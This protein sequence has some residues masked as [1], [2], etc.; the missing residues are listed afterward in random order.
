ME[1][2]TA[3]QKILYDQSAE[4]LMA[5]TNLTWHNDKLYAVFHYDTDTNILLMMAEVDL[6]N[7]QEIQFHPIT[8]YE[9]DV[10]PM[11]FF[12]N[13]NSIT[14]KGDR[15]L[16]VD[17][18]GNVHAYDPVTYQDRVLFTFSDYACQE[19][20]QNEKVYFS[21]NRLYFYYH[22][23]EPGTH[24]IDTYSLDGSRENRIK[25]PGIY[26]TFGGDTLFLYD[27]GILH[28]TMDD[29]KKAEGELSF[30]YLHVQTVN[31]PRAGSCTD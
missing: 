21:Q 16:F 23:R 25:I 15:L 31:Q 6:S 3:Y 14:S 26:K 7:R 13:R 29:I 9:K 12:F 18:F 30:R 28:D 20:W 1:N 27:F 8:S 11:H 22:D 17:G 5:M 10:D 19:Y 4:H 24:V 2:V